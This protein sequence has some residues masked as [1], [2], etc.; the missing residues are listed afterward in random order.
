MYGGEE[1]SVRILVGK[2][3]GK[4]PLRRPGR[5]WFIILK[6][7]FTKWD[8]GMDWIDLAQN[9]DG[10]RGSCEC[11]NEPSCSIRCRE[12]LGQLRTC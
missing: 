2:P 5:K 4:G 11:S 1:I 6:C 3:E 10:W 7:I 8:G 12:I 9:R